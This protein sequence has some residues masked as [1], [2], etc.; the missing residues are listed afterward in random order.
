MI[1]RVRKS[2]RNWLPSN[3]PECLVLPND[4]LSAYEDQGNL[5][6]FMERFEYYAD[7]FCDVYILNVDGRPVEYDYE[8]IH[9]LNVK[10]FGFKPLDLLYQLWLSYYY[11]KKLKVDF[12]RSLESSTYIKSGLMGIA[13]KLAGVPFT[14]SIHGSYRGLWQSLNYKWYHKL[15]FRPMEFVTHHTTDAVFVIDSMYTDELK[16]DNISLIPNFVDTSLF[17]PTNAKKTWAAIYVGSLIQKKNIP[18]LVS[19][20]IKIYAETGKKVAVVGH[21]PDKILLDDKTC[22]EYLGPVAHKDLPKYY[23]KSMSFITT[24]RHEGFAIPLVEAQACGL[25]IVATDLPPF[26]NNTV[27]NSSSILIKPND[28]IAFANAVIE[29]VK[30]KDL[31]NRMGMLGRQFVCMHFDKARVLDDE[32]RLV[33]S[34]M[35]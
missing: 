32:I 34:V 13:S 28:H 3:C 14:C 4:P 15:I 30:D 7:R 26:H 10:S 22:I 16:W 18:C 27:P 2:G 21:G 17:K 25:P 31:R 9:I 20:A 1:T 23:N 11:S 24:T 12:N 8:N 29:I 33:K 6:Q 19:A 35:R 5:G